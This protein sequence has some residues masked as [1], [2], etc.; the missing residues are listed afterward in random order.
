MKAFILLFSALLGN[1]AAPYAGA[2]VQGTLGA[3]S[4]FIINLEVEI[5]R[6]VRVFRLTDINLGTFDFSQPAQSAQDLFCVHDSGAA[7]GYTYNITFNGTNT[8]GAFELD[9]AGNTIAYEVEF[10]DT[11]TGSGLVP[12]MAG[13][14]IS[15]NTNPSPN[16][17]NC[18]PTGA[19]DNAMVRVTVL[20]S[21][22]T[23]APAGSYSD[24]LSITVAPDP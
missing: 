22:A 24:I 3:T 4:T 14:P 23:G 7:S 17:G 13:V 19:A 9:S 6:R 1:M 18:T 11:N 16:T 15:G 21:A 10:D 12:V 20:N 8:P 2:V 5:F